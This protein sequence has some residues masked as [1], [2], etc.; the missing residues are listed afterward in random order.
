LNESGQLADAGLQ[1]RLE[2]QARG[3]TE[4]VEKLRVK[5]LR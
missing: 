2:D 1:K 5:K 3:F 4:F